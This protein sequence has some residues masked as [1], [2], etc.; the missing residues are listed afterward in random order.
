MT[1]GP[2]HQLL[3]HFY[4]LGLQHL[5]LL[6]QL[7]ILLSPALSLPEHPRDLVDHRFLKRREKASA[8][9]L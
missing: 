9:T 6:E 1:L 2:A 5:L 4:Y 3:Q 8:G 7:E